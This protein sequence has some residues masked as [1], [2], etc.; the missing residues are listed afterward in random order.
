MT[1]L[2][3]FS[4]SSE[5]RTLQREIDQLF[6]SFFPN[7]QSENGGAEKANWTPRVD[8][9]ENDEEYLLHLDLPGMTKEDISISFQDGTLSVSGERKAE[10]K[11]EDENFV[12]VERA[13]GHFYRS[14]TLPKQ[15]KENKISAEYENGVL[16]IHVPKAEE[17]KPRQIEVH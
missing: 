13:A 14:F 10:T 6:D 17:T 2:T 11:R 4:P 5:M 7:R 15:I 8:L 16:R 1:R 3:R 12:R 9:S